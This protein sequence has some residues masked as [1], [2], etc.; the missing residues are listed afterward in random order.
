MYGGKA[1]TFLVKN[2]VCRCH[3]HYCLPYPKEIK[4]STS[5]VLHQSF[6]AKFSDLLRQVPVVT[7]LLPSMLAIRRQYRRLNG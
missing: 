7:P 6:T 1:G 3:P 4:Q 2:Y 5:A